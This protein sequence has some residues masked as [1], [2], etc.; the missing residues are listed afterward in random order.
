MGRTSPIEVPTVLKNSK[1][2]MTSDREAGLVEELAVD[3]RNIARS[4]RRCRV[5]Q[6]TPTPWWIVA[7]HVWAPRLGPGVFCFIGC[8]R[9]IYIF[10]EM[11]EPTP[12]YNLGALSCALQNGKKNTVFERKINPQE[13]ESA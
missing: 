11:D 4:L 13:L 2:P 1:I 6:P 12:S 10:S 7:L 9:Q 8:V 5:S 3:H